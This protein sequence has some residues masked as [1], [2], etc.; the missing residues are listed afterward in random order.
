MY[1]YYNPNPC[2]RIVPIP[3]YVVQNPNCCTNY[4]T[5]GCGV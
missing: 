3:A 1:I 4:N 2:G 5:C